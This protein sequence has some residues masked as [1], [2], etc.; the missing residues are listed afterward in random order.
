MILPMS[1]LRRLSAVMLTPNSVTRSFGTARGDQVEPGREAPDLL[2]DSRLELG[3]GGIVQRL[4][5][6][7]IHLLIALT[8]QQRNAGAKPRESVVES[9][10]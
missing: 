5:P 4:P 1:S 10:L 3:T 7:A 9:H 2:A 6:D 8:R